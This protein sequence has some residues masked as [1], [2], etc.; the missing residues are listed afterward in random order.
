MSRF[1]LG[2]TN[3]QIDDTI[4]TTDN[5]WSA[6]KT[7]SEINNMLSNLTLD[8][9]SDV[10]TTG[11]QDKYILQYD[12]ATSKFIVV[13]LN[14]ND[15]LKNLLDVNTT[16]IQD[17]Y[18]LQYDI[19]TSKFVSVP[20]KIKDAIDIDFT[21]IQDKWLLQYDSTAQKFKAVKMFNITDLNDINT[22]NLNDKSLLQYD[23]ANSEFKS[24]SMFGLGDL[25]NIDLT[26]LSDSY[27][28]IY[29]EEKKKFICSPFV[30]KSKLMELLDVDFTGITD[31]SLIYYSASV[32]KFMSKKLSI[33]DL[34]DVDLTGVQQDYILKYDATKNKFIVS[35]NVSGSNTSNEY[36]TYVNNTAQVNKLGIVADATTP[37]IVD[38]DIPY[39]ADFNLGKLEVL[40][41]QSASSDSINE[42]LVGFDN[43]DSSSFTYDA[44]SVV[45]DGK[46][47][48]NIGYSASGSDISD[49][50]IPSDS[51]LISFYF[52]PNKIDFDKITNIILNY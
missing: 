17:K 5:I 48:I 18:I 3:I 35:Y 11:I 47:R 44:N 20:V 4:Q 9:L 50:A 36:N 22:T 41:L 15:N 33:S 38:I 29:S 39:T 25:A 12:S 37:K 1:F 6:S 16:G 26:G 34:Q 14:K 32:Q 51:K 30:S 2:K 27:T 28:I 19:A 23:L 46:M 43:S 24:V 7:N 10:N 42:F 8:Q 52:D 45:F 21:G 49:T 31:N 40:N 13:A